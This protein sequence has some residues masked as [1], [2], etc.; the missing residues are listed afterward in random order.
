MYLCINHF[1][2]YIC[3]YKVMAL[4]QS[5]TQRLDQ[6]LSPQQIQLMKL[7]QI[8][9]IEL[10]QRI[11]DEMEINPA[12]EEGVQEGAEN[13]DLSNT[14]ES[15]DLSADTQ[16]DRE[17]SDFDISVYFDQDSPDYQN[18]TNYQ[19]RSTD[20]RTVHTVGET[21]F[22]ER[23]IDQLTLVD[24]D[25]TQR[26]IAEALIGNLDDSG[27]LNRE[28]SSIVDDLAFS[29]NIFV[30]LQD[31]E[32]VLT[33]IQELD[34]AGVGARNLRECLLLQ[35]QRRQNG[36]I[37][38]YTALK[39]IENH[40]DEI[41]KKH[42]TA[43]QRK[44]E[45][46]ETDLKEAIEEI[47]KLNPKPGGSSGS[48]KDAEKNRL[49]ITPDFTVFE[50]EG[51]LELTING[52]HAPELRVSKDYENLLRSYAENATLT[53]SNRHTMQF[54]RQK[55][56]SA[57][58]FIDA[59]KQRHNTLLITMTAIM[60][61]QRDFFLTGDESLL[62]PMILRD[63]ADA[64]GMDLST[65]SRVV[66]S[67][68]V[69]TNYGIFPLRYFFAEAVASETGEEISIREMKQILLDAV[70]NEDKQNP[71]TDER[72]AEIF[73]EKGYAIARR[74][75]AKYR[76]QLHIPVARLRKEL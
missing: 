18:Q 30:N 31:V 10:N 58:W 26:I 63:I 76:E 55:L 51:R 42:Y 56:D 71:L 38:R 33:I 20:D 22:R 47:V 41:T 46:S 48:S 44:L 64:I 53:K 72:I 36:N 50:F 17:D 7:L 12:L 69:Q 4:K 35:L 3:I 75:I 54:V 52:R 73:L 67:K 60:N 34:P 29:T 11:K 70:A 8:P 16:S 45:I 27:Y 13:A 25:E 62:R 32:Q 59:I 23:L 24:L 37:T 28:L 9:A 40:F 14:E 74:T 49:T 19:Q 2:E 21:T 15:I 43:I 68:H 6:R 65:V 61:F 5:L 57:R 39:L 66:N 1:G